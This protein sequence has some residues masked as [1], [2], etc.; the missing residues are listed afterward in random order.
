MLFHIPSNERERKFKA[1]TSDLNNSRNNIFRLKEIISEIPNEDEE[2]IT[3]HKSIC[4]KQISKSADPFRDTNCLRKNIDRINETLFCHDHKI[5]MIKIKSNV[6]EN[7]SKKQNENKKIIERVMNIKSKLKLE[8]LSKEKKIG[9]KFCDFK[10][11]DT[12]MDI[13]KFLKEI[14]I[15]EDPKFKEFLS[16]LKE[17]FKEN[18]K[19]KPIAIEKMDFFQKNETALKDAKKKVSEFYSQMTRKTN[20]SS[21]NNKVLNYLIEESEKNVLKERSDLDHETNQMKNRLLNMNY[22]KNDEYHELEPD[23]VDVEAFKE[24]EEIK[25]MLLMLGINLNEKKV[26]IFYKNTDVYFKTY[27]EQADKLRAYVNRLMKG[28][29]NKKWIESHQLNANGDSLIKSS[30]I[31]N[32]NEVLS[33]KIQNNEKNNTFITNLDK[34][35]N[36]QESQNGSYFKRTSLSLQSKIKQKLERLMNAKNIFPF[37]T[38]NY[39]NSEENKSEIQRKFNRSLTYSVFNQKN[40][41]N[42]MSASNNHKINMS[43]LKLYPQNFIDNTAVFTETKKK[44]NTLHV[45]LGKANIRSSIQEFHRISNDVLKE[46]RKSL[47]KSRKSVYIPCPFVNPKIKVDLSNIKKFDEILGSIKERNK[48]LTKFQRFL[49]DVDNTKENYEKKTAV[50]GRN[51]DNAFEDMDILQEKMELPVIESIRDDVYTDE[52]IENRNAWHKKKM[53][54]NLKKTIRLVLSQKK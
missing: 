28:I 2:Q 43:S 45:K 16:S 54:K 25:R 51:I 22:S 11:M 48:I 37:I 41:K 10:K 21:L 30:Q 15:L 44:S 38:K 26:D 7:N 3:S 29:F 4:S 8:N 49:N 47:R 42:D 50:Y 32:A 35:T 34:N 13:E 19:K 27:K 14:N 1:E 5:G 36:V 52:Y 9:K 33:N 20:V 46:Q 53:N 40:Q 24:L 6:N 12:F 17:N 39:E 18:R 31:L 23:Q